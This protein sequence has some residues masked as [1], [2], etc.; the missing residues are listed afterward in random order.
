MKIRQANKNDLKEIVKIEKICFPKAE[1]ASEKD[2]YERFEVFGE[3][4]LVAEKDNKIIGF[5][6][7]CTTDEP[8][9]PDELYSNAKLH[10]PNGDYQTLFGLDV[11][12]EYSRQGV[13]GKLLRSL[14]DLAKKRGKEGMV[15]TCKDHL[16][17]FYESN[18]FEF[19]GVSK[20][21]HGGA[22]WNDMLLIF[23]K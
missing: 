23:D 15:L 11:L 22:K 6:N 12:P 9:L 13:A 3:N 18:G 2:I 19:Q 16:I 20:S 8:N 17:P 1:A 10:K 14:I 4:F 5:I 7:G 21:C